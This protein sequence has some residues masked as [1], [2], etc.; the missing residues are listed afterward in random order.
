MQE[1]GGAAVAGAAAVPCSVWPATSSRDSDRGHH[2][3][4]RGEAD[5]AYHAALSE[6][7]R[8]LVLGAEAGQLAGVYRIVGATPMEFLPHVVLE[9][10][11]TSGES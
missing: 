3:D 11:R 5:L 9:L 6:P 1:L 7:N 4:H 10:I 8:Q 2:H